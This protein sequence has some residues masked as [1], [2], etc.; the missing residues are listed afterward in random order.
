VRNKAAAADSLR[1]STAKPREARDSASGIAITED[2]KRVVL[3]SEI[4]QGWKQQGAT[5]VVWDLEFGT[6][7]RA[8]PFGG[9]RAFAIDGTARR[10]ASSLLE[11]AIG[12]WNL[13]TGEQTGTL[14]PGQQVEKC[15][16]SE[17]GSFALSLSPHVCLAHWETA[18]GALLWSRT[19][20]LA[21]ARAIAASPDLN[22]G[23]HVSAAQVRLWDL[24][25]GEPVGGGIDSQKL[26]VDDLAVGNDRRFLVATEDRLGAWEISDRWGFRKV[27]LSRDSNLG[28]TISADA[29][30]LKLWDMTGGKSC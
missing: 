17:D 22:F 6:L 24:V 20:S 18:T 29:P 9:G 21:H 5:L 8:V 27:C 16:L 15:V 25:S 13:D 26:Q 3:L 12:I 10:V 23:V 14:A 2:G 19:I 4:T 28:L 30:Y 11:G 1:S 7:D